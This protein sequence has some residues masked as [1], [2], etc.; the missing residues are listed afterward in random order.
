MSAVRKVIAVKM[1][2]WC[3]GGELDTL[4]RSCNVPDVLELVSAVVTI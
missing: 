2:D 1:L 3:R 4:L